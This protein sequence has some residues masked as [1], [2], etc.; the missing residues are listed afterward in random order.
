MSQSKPSSAPSSSSSSSIQS[1]VFPTRQKKRVRFSE[2]P[3]IVGM[4]QQQQQQ[5][6]NDC[7]GMCTC[8][9]DDSASYSIDQDRSLTFKVV[10]D[11]HSSA[12]R[13]LGVPKGEEQQFYRQIWGS[14]G[15]NDITST[16]ASAE[17]R[18]RWNYSNDHCKDKAPKAAVRRP[19]T[20]DIIDLALA[21]TSKK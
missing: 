21:V 7:Y 16:I 4:Q 5:Q 18:S 2:Q 15:F 20:R 11:K 17:Q 8:G 6:G 13:R 10:V 3:E 1:I 9:K 19:N 12:T 14:T